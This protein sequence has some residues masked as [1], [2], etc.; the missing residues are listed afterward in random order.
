MTW[1][2]P[3]QSS[4]KSIEITNINELKT[5]IA[6]LRILEAEQVTVL[7]QRLNSP[8][9]IFSSL[10]TVFP[11]KAAGNGKAAPGMLHLDILRLIS[12]LVIP[13]TLNKTLFRK[14]N[15]LVKTLVSLVSQKAAGFVSEPA[16][17]NLLTKFKAVFKALT[18]RKQKSKAA[19]V[20]PPVALLSIN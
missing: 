18:T 1:N 16:A 15:F 10:R 9:A 17:E 12:R 13:F 4:M 7:R 14:S 6:R 3:K 11:K 8:A 2:M 5:E 19:T 20:I